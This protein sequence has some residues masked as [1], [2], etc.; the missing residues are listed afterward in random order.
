MD[1]KEIRLITGIDASGERIDAF[2]SSAAEGMSRNGIQKLIEE[3]AVTVNG[4][5]CDSKK[6]KVREG[7]EIVIAVPEPKRLDVEAEDIP[8]EIVYEDEHA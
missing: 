8:V 1:K 5:V 3:G 2:L 7:D 6:Y 4:D